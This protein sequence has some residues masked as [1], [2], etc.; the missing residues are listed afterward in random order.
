MAEGGDA[1]IKRQILLTLRSQQIIVSCQEGFEVSP[2]TDVTG[3][4]W[5]LEE[6]EA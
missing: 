3:L 4:V 6:E 2:C 1:L 5:S